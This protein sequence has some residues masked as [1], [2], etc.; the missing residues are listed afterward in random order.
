MFTWISFLKGLDLVKNG[1]DPQ[2]LFGSSFLKG[3]EKLVKNGPDHKFGC[4]RGSVF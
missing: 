4:L 3:L 2:R 1:P